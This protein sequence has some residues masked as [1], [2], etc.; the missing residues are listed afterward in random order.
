MT[1]A[2]DIRPSEAL[3]GKLVKTAWN[4]A[5][6]ES[7]VNTVENFYVSSDIIGTEDDSLWEQD[8]EEKY[9]TVMRVLAGASYS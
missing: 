8:F 3:R 7:V 9:A 6:P 4:D 1:P 2:G 5:S